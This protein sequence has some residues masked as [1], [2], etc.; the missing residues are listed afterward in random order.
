MCDYLPHT[1]EVCKWRVYAWSMEG[2]PGGVRTVHV[3]VHWVVPGQVRGPLCMA[4]A[5]PGLRGSGVQSQLMYSVGKGPHPF[6]LTSLPRFTLSSLRH[7]ASQY[8]WR[9]VD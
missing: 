6:T 8:L 9:V 4:V 5:S 7:T 3:V 2:Q 1:S